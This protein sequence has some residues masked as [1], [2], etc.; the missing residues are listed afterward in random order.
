MYPSTSQYHGQHQMLSEILF[1]HWLPASGRN[2]VSN[3]KAVFQTVLCNNN[4]EWIK[5]KFRDLATMDTSTK[6]YR[7]LLLA[8]RWSRCPLEIANWRNFE[9]KK[10]QY[11]KGLPS[12]RT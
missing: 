3:L 10:K 5:E 6:R 4:S 11:S 1:R 9:Q 7:T 2:T 12:A 8:V